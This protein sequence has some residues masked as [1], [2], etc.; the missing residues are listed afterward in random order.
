MQ[1]LDTAQ[2]RLRGHRLAGL[3]EQTRDRLQLADA[4][5]PPQLLISSQQGRV[6]AG[7]NDVGP[8]LE[9]FLVRD[10]RIQLHPFD[11]VPQRFA[12]P[13]GLLHTGAHLGVKF[14]ALKRR[15][16]DGDFQ[17]RWVPARQ[18]KVGVRRRRRTVRITGRCTLGDVQQHGTVTHRARHGMVDGH[19]R[20]A[21]ADMGA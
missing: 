7:V 13:G 9:V 6:H 21:L 8:V 3:A 12:Q 17:P 14:H 4:P 10:N 18:L 5:T 15:H 20:P 1:G 16:G 19:A 11:L 2:V